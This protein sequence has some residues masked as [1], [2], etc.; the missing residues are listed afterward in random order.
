MCLF[1]RN[2]QQC[3]GNS[4]QGRESNASPE[5]TSLAAQGPA[6]AEEAGHPQGVGLEHFPVS[7]RALRTLSFR[8]C[9]HN[10]GSN[11]HPQVRRENTKKIIS[12][13]TWC[14]HRPS[15]CFAYP[16]FLR[17]A[18]SQEQELPIRSVTAHGPPQVTNS[19]L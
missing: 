3:Q 10:K 9:Q 11:F 8:H 18:C 19:C 5:Q 16:L 1:L 14:L 12:H 4:H 17:Q 7:H 6:L 13:F 15:S 2:S